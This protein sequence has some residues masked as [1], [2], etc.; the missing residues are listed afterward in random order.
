ML[1]GVRRLLA[2]ESRAG[3]RGGQEK[4]TRARAKKD[5]KDAPD[6]RT[7]SYFTCQV[8]FLERLEKKLLAGSFATRESRRDERRGLLPACRVTVPFPSL[9]QL[10]HPTPAACAR[11][12]KQMAALAAAPPTPPPG[13]SIADT[14]YW[15][16]RRLKQLLFQ[17]EQF[18]HAQALARSV[19]AR[20]AFPPP[21]ANP[22]AWTKP[23]EDYPTPP[24]MG[25]MDSPEKSAA[26]SVRDKRGRMRLH[27]AEKRRNLLNLLAFDQFGHEVALLAALTG[28]HFTVVHDPA[29]LQGTPIDS[30]TQ[31]FQHEWDLSSDSDLDTPNERQYQLVS[32]TP[33]EKEQF[34][35]SGAAGMDSDKLME[36]AEAFAAQSGMPLSVVTKTATA[37]AVKGPE[38]LEQEISDCLASLVAAQEQNGALAALSARLQAGI[39]VDDAKEESDEEAKKEK[40]QLDEKLK[41]KVDQIGRLATR[42]NLAAAGKQSELLRQHILP[43]LRRQLAFLQQVQ[44]EAIGDDPT[45]RHLKEEVAILKGSAAAVTERVRERE[46]LYA[47]WP[48]EDEAQDKAQAKWDALDSQIENNR[49]AL[50]VAQDKVGRI[51]SDTRSQQHRL[52]HELFAARKSAAPPPPAVS[53]KSALPPLP[54]AVP[55]LAD[56]PA[57]L[58]TAELRAKVNAYAST[59]RAAK[60]ALARVSVSVQP[61]VDAEVGKVPSGI[62]Y[63]SEH[64]DDDNN[65]NERNDNRRANEQVQHKDAVAKDTA[66]LDETEDWRLGY[67]PTDLVENIKKAQRAAVVADRAHKDLHAALRAHDAT[68][69]KHR[70]LV[71]HVL[72]LERHWPQVDSEQA[73]A[74]ETWETFSKERDELQKKLKDQTANGRLAT[75][76]DRARSTDAMAT[77]TEDTAVRR[78]NAHADKESREKQGA[79]RRHA[80]RRD[81]KLWADEAKAANERSVSARNSADRVHLATCTR[82][83]GAAQREADTKRM[84]LKLETKTKEQAAAALDKCVTELAAVD[85]T[86]AELSEEQ[87]SERELLKAELPGLKQEVLERESR[88]ETARKAAQVAKRSLVVLSGKL[89]EALRNSAALAAQN[90]SEAESDLT[91]VE[92]QKLEAGTDSEAAEGL[93]VD[94]MALE[95][96][97]TRLRAIVEEKDM[98]VA[99]R[100]ESHTILEH[101]THS[102]FPKAGVNAQVALSIKRW[103]R[104]SERMLPVR[105]KRLLRE[106]LLWWLAAFD[107]EELQF[108]AAPVEKDSE[109]KEVETGDTDKAQREK[110]WLQAELQREQ[111]FHA[112]AEALAEQELAEAMQR[113]RGNL[114]GK[115]HQQQQKALLKTSA[116][117]RWLAARTRA[118]ALL[119]FQQ[120]KT[121]WNHKDERKQEREVKRMMTARKC[122]IQDMNAKRN[123]LWAQALSAKKDKTA[124]DSGISAQ[125]SSPL[126]SAQ[127]ALLASTAGK[128]E[129]PLNERQARLFEQTVELGQRMSSQRVTE[130]DRDMRKVLRDDF[131][132]LQ[133]RLVGQS[134]LSVSQ[135]TS[136]I[137][138]MGKIKQRDYGHRQRQQSGS[139]MG[140]KK[141]IEA[142]LDRKEEETEQGNVGNTRRASVLEITRFALGLSDDVTD[143]DAEDAPRLQ[144]QDASSSGD[145]TKEQEESDSET[146]AN[147][148]DDGAGGANSTTESTGSTENADGFAG[149]A[150]VEARKFGPQLVGK[151]EIA[152]SLHQ[153]A[154]RASISLQQGRAAPVHEVNSKLKSDLD[155]WLQEVIMWHQDLRETEALLTIIQLEDRPHT[156]VAKPPV[157]QVLDFAA[158]RIQAVWR[159]CLAI[160]R[161][162]E[163]WM[164]LEAAEEEE[165]AMRLQ[166]AIRGRLVRNTLKRMRDHASNDLSWDN[167]LVEPPIQTASTAPTAKP[168][169]AKATEAKAPAPDSGTLSLPPAER[170]RLATGLLPTSHAHLDQINVKTAVDSASKGNGEEDAASTTTS[171]DDV[172][173][174]LRS[175]A[176]NTSASASGTSGTAFLPSERLDL[177]LAHWERPLLAPEVLSAMRWDEGLINEGEDEGSEGGGK[178]EKDADVALAFSNES[179]AFPA[180]DEKGAGGISSS[181]NP[182][183]LPVRTVVTVGEVSDSEDEGVEKSKKFQDLSDD[184][185]SS[186]S[187]DSGSGSSSEEDEEEDQDDADADSSR[188]RRFEPEWDRAAISNPTAER[189]ASVLFREPLDAPSAAADG[190]DSPE[191]QDPTLAL[192]PEETGISEDERQSRLRRARMALARARKRAVDAKAAEKA[193]QK[194]AREE[195]LATIKAAKEAAAKREREMA[196]RKKEKAERE[197][198]K[199]EQRAYEAAALKAKAE[200]ERKKVEEEQEERKR[201]KALKAVDAAWDAESD[202][203]SES[204]SGSVSESEA[205][206]RNYYAS[207]AGSPSSKAGASPPASAPVV[208]Y[209]AGDEEAMKAKQQEGTHSGNLN[210]NA[211]DSPSKGA[212]VTALLFPLPVSP[213]RVMGPPQPVH[214]LSR[215]TPESVAQ[216]HGIT[217]DELLAL[218]RGAL[219]PGTD[220]SARLWQGTALILPPGAKLL[221]LSERAPEPLSPGLGGSQHTQQQQQQQ[222]EQQQ[223]QQQRRSPRKQAQSGVSS[224]TSLLRSASRLSTTHMLR[225][226]Q[227]K[228]SNSTGVGKSGGSP[229]HPGATQAAADVLA[230]FAET[231]LL[232]ADRTSPRLVAFGVDKR[233]RQDRS[234]N[235]PSSSPARDSHTAESLANVAAMAERARHRRVRPPSPPTFAQSMAGPGA[236]G[237]GGGGGGAVNFRPSSNHALEARGP[238]SEP[239]FLARAPNPDAKITSVANITKTRA[240][241]NERRRMRSGL[242]SRGIRE[243]GA[244]DRR[245]AREMS[246]RHADETRELARLSRKSAVSTQALEAQY[247]IGP[248]H[249][250]MSSDSHAGKIFRQHMLSPSEHGSRAEDTRRRAHL[251]RLGRFEHVSGGTTI[252]SV[253]NVKFTARMLAVDPTT[254]VPMAN[255]GGAMGV[256][257]A[258]YPGA[259]LVVRVECWSLG[260]A[261]ELRHIRNSENGVGCVL[262]VTRGTLVGYEVQAPRQSTIVVVGGTGDNTQDS[263]PGARNRRTKTRKKTVD[264]C[265]VL[266]QGNTRVVDLTLA[267][268]ARAV[269]GTAT[270]KLKIVVGQRFANLRFRVAVQRA[271]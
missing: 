114:Q 213:E 241:H 59:E 18:K 173:S 240:G 223:Q 103:H 185:S 217:L 207:A 88:C 51:L 253:D 96:K 196:Q 45:L 170:A 22:V 86:S 138:E 116:R 171:L 263:R 182:T 117:S 64:D 115:Q 136:L 29:T 100:S 58:A 246:R 13:D 121:G 239:W 148:L 259:R 48:Q 189:H 145:D 131:L 159:A 268:S 164:E 30:D 215:D 141:T 150:V 126:T 20:V 165:A 176:P 169:K 214:A 57:D 147:D 123:N 81:S 178:E 118:R 161:V 162:F 24:D 174:S 54:P 218:N 157:S 61:L 237:Q 79:Q 76:I 245:A 12:Q 158:T 4:R 84:R 5:G 244:R 224:R 232:T 156:P 197:A 16:G 221:P 50:A 203:N 168:T 269:P 191:A 2:N 32:W 212:R 146:V 234:R 175:A 130:A 250:M 68:V 75:L 265:R 60:A 216:A 262:P 261:D 271:L 44:F 135:S 180:R 264:P 34:L 28:A 77:E 15:V 137:N 11:R 1:V 172:L 188:F 198:R 36:A 186:S 55:L 252:R 83:T 108:R 187:S 143:S 219:P 70:M 78:S 134:A 74:Q 205:I 107:A 163:V 125:W 3:S 89:V 200:A 243:D 46:Q 133:A 193:A 92:A 41:V 144:S 209:I 47:D 73:A 128:S 255:A 104:L 166:A 238:N 56:T 31:A 122:A 266:W 42:T 19:G 257:P 72:G 91:V 127:Q 129:A 153:T 154:H 181:T 222:Q 242:L 120:D 226:N 192:D 247:R 258:I 23:A 26:V 202:E 155:I 112:E 119:S 113:E 249:A 260:P 40:G 62:N 105:R 71:A 149:D 98:L 140:N 230:G 69:I 231:P 248:A 38:A 177:Q 6:L 53:G 80:A 184:E 160:S 227:Q 49:N 204:S 206:Y 190:N 35:A 101:S 65:R 199:A 17:T 9:A 235:S 167:L 211:V 43:A 151:D 85:S 229:V 132:S 228:K 14:Q 25:W 142:K 251:E 254:G 33:E 256:L 10:T 201:Q 195:R 208:V 21:G 95:R 87:E 63:V 99:K 52:E 194:K 270:V 97:C 183:P 82:R 236:V 210:T 27:L 109:T 90:L 179:S 111:K 225:M 220:T 67:V 93:M 66:V 124:N 139:A 8:Y 106:A 102:V 152:K 94:S 267:C 7:G 37:Q 233:R 39:L 110:T